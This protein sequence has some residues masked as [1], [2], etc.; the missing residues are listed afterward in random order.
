MGRKLR[1]LGPEDRAIIERLHNGGAPA[2]VIA[3]KVGVHPA[4]IYRELP[5]GY[6]EVT[7][8][9]GSPTPAVDEYGRRVYDAEVAQRTF[10]RNIKRRGERARAK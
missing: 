5:N 3:D 7:G 1:Y 9:D 6:T 10:E 4:T 8:E 2:A